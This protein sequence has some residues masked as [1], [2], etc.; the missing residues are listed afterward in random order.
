[1]TQI[2]S[3]GMD[4][5]EDLGLWPLN[6]KAVLELALEEG[7]SFLGMAGAAYFLQRNEG[8]EILELQER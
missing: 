2:K 4:A 1:M 3:F 5:V 8:K 6:I 7:Y